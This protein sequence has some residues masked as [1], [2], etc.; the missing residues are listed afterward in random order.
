M[1]PFFSSVMIAWRFVLVLLTF[2]NIGE[3]VQSMKTDN[4]LHRRGAAF[5]V[6]VLVVIRTTASYFSGTPLQYMV[7]DIL[8]FSIIFQTLINAASGKSALAFA[9]RSLREDGLGYMIFAFG[10]CIATDMLLVSEIHPDFKMLAATVCEM[11]FHAW[12][13]FNNKELTDSICARFESLSA[14]PL[15]ILSNDEQ[16][17]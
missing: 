14:P 16:K 9:S 8:W 2:F 5:S 10:V 7:F 12:V 11:T 17:K 4:E 3:R 15:R 1:D 6:L 13:V